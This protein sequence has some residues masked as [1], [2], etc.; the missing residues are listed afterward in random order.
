VARNKILIV[1]DEPGVR[2]GVR[3]FLESSG[4]EVEEA[5]SWQ[6]AVE[7][8]QVARPDAAII[9]YRLPDGDALELLPRLKGIDPG[10]PL[11]ILTAHGSIDLAVR[12]VKEGADQLLTKPVELPTLLVLLQRLLQE[13][14]NRQRRIA[15]RTRR[16]RQGVDPFLGI[17]ARIRELADEVRRIVSS[18]SPVLIL[19][20][21]GTGKGILARWLHDHGSRAE[22]AFI[23][24]NCAGLVREFLES[25]LFGHEKG[26]FTGAVNSKAGLLE[27]AH[28][29]TVF[30]DEIGDMDL[31]VQPK[32]LKVLE[33]KRFRR[34]GEVRDRWVDIRLIAATHQDP[35]NLVRDRKF[36][37]DLYFR[38]N[39]ITLVVPPL[40]ERKEDIPVISRSLLSKLAADLGRGEVTLA[41]DAERA[42]QA[43]AWPG[44]IRELR[45]IL[46]RALLISDRSILSEG[47]L[48]FGPPAAIANG[49]ASNHVTL[50]EL[51]RR[52]IERVLQD[53]QGRVESAAMKLGIP[54][55]TL[56]QKIKQYQIV[57][58]KP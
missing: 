4:F 56:Y 7:I 10:I 17:S 9:D 54:R 32:L 46:E 28:R 25:E 34:L 43:H 50:R 36:R 23:D 52:H 15:G 12:A 39:T 16:A 5:D 27:V 13:Q 6:A 40:R 20:E 26:A 44:N 18:D 47:D 41:P 35:A 19:G 2:F 30:L 51:E 14:R 11:I 45:N 48:R 55:S 33:D 42:L 38:V 57:L 58:P 31:Q 22:E 8:F 1:D 29:G 37:D 49:S 24:L 53:E 21:T 3:D